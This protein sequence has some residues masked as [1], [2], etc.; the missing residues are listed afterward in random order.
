MECS[1]IYKLLSNTHSYLATLFNYH[2]QFFFP[3]AYFRSNEFNKWVLS[4]TFFIIIVAVYLD[5]FLLGRVMTFC[6]NIKIRS[7]YVK[8]YKYLI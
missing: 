8:F 3:H 5:H 4:T 1:L 2:R 6:L 7:N